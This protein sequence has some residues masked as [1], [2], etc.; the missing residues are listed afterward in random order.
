MHKPKKQKVDAIEEIAITKQIE[1]L[2]SILISIYLENENAD[3]KW[4]TKTSGTANGKA[5]G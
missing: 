2:A 4:N 3:E 1:V 5:E